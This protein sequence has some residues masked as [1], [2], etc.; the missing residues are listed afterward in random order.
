MREFLAKLAEEGK[1]LIIDKPVNPRHI[2]S[3]LSQA[4]GPILMKNIEGYEGVS[5]SGGIFTS[6]EMVAKVL[7]CP[8]RELAQGFNRLIQKSVSPAV[9]DSGPVKEVILRGDEVD[10]TRLPIPLM[11]KG[12]GGPYITGGMVIAKDI[13]GE[14]GTN[15]GMYRLMFRSKNETGIDLVT[16]SDLRTYYERALERGKA[17]P[18]SIAIGISPALMV[19]ATYKAPIGV[20]EY[21]IAGGIEGK[22]TEIVAS[23]TNDIFVPANAEIIL[24][25][26]MLPIGWVEQEGPFGEFAGYQ[27]ESKWNPIV[28]IHCMTYRKNPM[29]YALSMPWE[30]DWLLAASTE[31]SVF[32]AIQC[33]GVKVKEVRTTIGG[34]CFWQ[35][36]ASIEKRTGEGKNALLAALSVGAVKLAI[37]TDDDVDIFN[38]DELDRAL[39]FRVRPEHDVMVIS[40]ARANHVDPSVEAWKLP[41]GEL[42][43]TSKLG[44]DAT[45][46]EGIPKER[47]QLIE[48]YLLDAVNLSDYLGS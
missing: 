48:P 31:A 3:L 9:V 46:P 18:V 42:P 26:E 20:S 35:V 10:L 1:L 8:D 12:D 39:V 29:Y 28:K 23:E 44:I 45:M 36:I 43:M 38:Q 6:R 7:N 4:K 11:H 30:N 19:A 2:S 15:L 5:V 21:E 34:A 14:Y 13:L 40:G 17:L 24:E 22:P 41:K 37:V 32:R 27:G 47:Y 25:G 16:A 33:A